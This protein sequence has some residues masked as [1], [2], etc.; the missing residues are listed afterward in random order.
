MKVAALAAGGTALVATISGVARVPFL[1]T[2][3]APQ[4]RPFVAAAP[5][6]PKK[7]TPFVDPLVIPPALTPRHYDISWNRLL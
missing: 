6:K 2:D 3:E 4:Q 7:L 5:M 1:N